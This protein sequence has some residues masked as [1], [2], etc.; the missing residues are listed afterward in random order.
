MGA[1]YQRACLLFN[2]GR[3]ELAERELREELAEN[4]HSGRAHAFLGRCLAQQKRWT[5]A[6]AEGEEAVGLAPQLAYTHYMLGLTYGDC[7]RL[8]EAEAALREA[9]RLHSRNVACLIS[10]SWIQFR[11]GDRRG[12]LATTEQGLA[13]DPMHSGCLSHRGMYQR[14]LR[15]WRGAE[16]TLRESLRLDPENGHAHANMAWALYFKAC[17]KGGSGIWE[18]HGQSALYKSLQHCQEAL[19]LDPSS[20]FARTTAA[21]VLLVRPRCII[22]PFGLLAGLVGLL[23]LLLTVGT[24]GLRANPPA[25][26]L[27]LDFP[28]SVVPVLLGL[29]TVALSGG[30]FYLLMR[31]T[32]LGEAVLLPGQRRAA[33]VTAAWLGVTIVA[34]IVALFA[35]PLTA[36]AVLFIGLALIGPMT[37]ACRSPSGSA[38]KLMTAYCVLLAAVGLTCLA[39]AWC[40]NRANGEKASV[41]VAFWGAVASL[42]SAPVG[43]L[44]EK[45]FAKHAG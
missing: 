45:V 16:E 28:A 30:P 15:N 43:K 38:R 7:D 9:L 14:V 18:R 20:E 3:Y 21:A 1:H 25:D 23:I 8:K 5:E 19:R 26:A 29:L 32:R 13:I 35:V 41:A 22:C 33:N 31:R 10:L 40:V 42:L 34:F 12:A 37:V 39:F 17:A 36:P 2:Q 6:L 27:P 44:L 11:R 4:P 24:G